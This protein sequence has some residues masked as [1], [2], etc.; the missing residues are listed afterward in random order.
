M[1]KSISTIL[2]MLICTTVLCACNKQD[3]QSVSSNEEKTEP[4]TNT[5]NIDKYAIPADAPNLVY[6]AFKYKDEI[7]NSVS[8]NYTVDSII[9]IENVTPVNLKKEITIYNKDLREIGT[10]LE[11]NTY[12]CVGYNDSVIQLVNNDSELAYI[13]CKDFLDNSSYD[14]M[15]EFIKAIDN[16]AKQKEQIEVTEAKP[17]S[18]SDT[19]GTGQG[20]VL[21]TLKEGIYNFYLPFLDGENSGEVKIYRNDTLQST[22]ILDKTCQFI[23]M[24]IGKDDV[25]E[26]SYG[27]YYERIS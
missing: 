5:L 26:V 4:V 13:T 25:L 2:V 9:K 24:E 10:T 22:T 19:S 27:V 8:G 23:E 7:G 6:S 18:V 11:N 14:S 3:T 15:E 1:K 20:P 17:L 12:L 21:F 16:L